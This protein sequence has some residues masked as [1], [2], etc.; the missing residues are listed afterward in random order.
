M[1]KPLP[2]LDQVDAMRTY[3][4]TL[5]ADIRRA[6]RDESVHYLKRRVS[7]FVVSLRYARLF[8]AYELEEVA[9]ECL[10]QLLQARAL[11]IAEFFPGDQ[12]TMEVI[13]KGYERPPERYIVKDVE[14]S[15]PDSYHYVAWQLTK[16]GQLFQRG[17]AGWFSPSNRISLAA[18]DAPLPE[19]TRRQCDWFRK[20]ASE[21][22]ENVQGRGSIEATV[23]L[24]S[25]RRMRHT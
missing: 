4:R 5:R 14:W 16:G 1:R 18:S 11:S 7:P 3:L 6:S 13:V 2:L 12:I 20:K 22:M 17:P 21:F 24:V 15:K 9:Q 25:D 10:K 23:K 8:R 19:E